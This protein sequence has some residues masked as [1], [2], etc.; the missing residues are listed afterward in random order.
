MLRS[1]NDL[2]SWQGFSIKV[3]QRPDGRFEA[4]SKDLNAR[5]VPPTVANSVQIATAMHS[6]KLRSALNKGEAQ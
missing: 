2:T 3:S 5:H 6:D 4:T 1:S